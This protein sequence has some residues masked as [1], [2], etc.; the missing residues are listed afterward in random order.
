VKQSVS[1]FE[2]GRAEFFRPQLREGAKYTVEKAA[3]SPHESRRVSKNQADPRKPVTPIRPFF[4]TEHGHAPVIQGKSVK[5]EA[6][7]VAAP[8]GQHARSHMAA[9]REI[10]A[11]I[12]RETIVVY[13]A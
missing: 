11:D 8:V 6:A 2:T 1:K 10:R 12:D 13:Q 4:E 9:S 5:S 7:A 3:G